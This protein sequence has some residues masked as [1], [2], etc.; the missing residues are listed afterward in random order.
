[1]ICGPISLATNWMASRGTKAYQYFG[2]GRLNS[3][4]I[5]SRLK[6]SI[7]TETLPAIKATETGDWERPATNGLALF[8]VV[9]RR[10]IPVSSLGPVGTWLWLIGDRCFQSRVRHVLSSAGYRIS[11]PLAVQKPKGEERVS[12]WHQE[13]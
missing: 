6:N 10:S 12:Y 8:L 7:P 3:D 11:D 2:G 9:V 4:R 13:T 1:M 5:V